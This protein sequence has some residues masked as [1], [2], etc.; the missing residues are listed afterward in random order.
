MQPETNH[1]GEAVPKRKGRRLRKREWREKCLMSQAI[2]RTMR[3]PKLLSAAMPR[4][5][6]KEEFLQRPRSPESEFG[7]KFVPPSLRVEMENFIGAA[8]AAGIDARV[9]EKEFIRL[10]KADRSP[11]KWDKY[12]FNQL[13]SNTDGKAVIA[14]KPVPNK[15][16]YEVYAVRKN[17]NRAQALHKMKSFEHIGTS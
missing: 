12:L 8:A 16:G 6:L 11:L 14:E 3:C 7:L 1:Q 4:V 5:I 17:V 9:A 13:I 15:I 10:K 2:K